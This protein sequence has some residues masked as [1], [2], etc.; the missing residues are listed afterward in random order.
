MTSPAR[1]GPRAWVVWILGVAAYVAAVLQRTS[2]GVAGLEATDRFGVPASGLAAFT[3]LQLLVYAALQVPAG[4][5]LDRFGSRR[6]ITAGA[7]VMAA[8]Q[9]VLAAATAV[10]LAVLGRV[11]VGAGDAV[12]FVSVL[13]LVA[14]WFPPARV[15]L[16]AQVTGLVGQ[17]GQILSAVPLVALL[18][19]SGWAPAFGGAAAVGVVVA[20]A[21]WVG[22]LDAPGVRVQAGPPL[23]FRQ[24]R[25][26]LASAWRHPGTRLGLWT[27][28]TTQFPGTVFALVW[29]YPFLV[30][31]EGLSP[32]V[33]SALLTVFVLAGMVAGPVLG[34]MA[35]RHPLRRSWL[36]LATIGANVAG[37][38]A[39]IAHPGPAP[40][41]LLVVLVLALATGGPGSLVGLDFA[42]T[43][44]PVQRL[45]TA[46]GLVNIGG[47][48]ASLLVVLAVGVVL[49]LTGGEY[50]LDGF[51]LAFSTQ[52][53]V[54]AVGL[55]GIL[56]TRRLVRRRMADEGLV[57]PPLRQALARERLAR[58]RAREA[59]REARRR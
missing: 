41:W 34:V 35:G 25:D 5:A 39:V 14:V 51:R 55:V 59:A 15:P 54:W 36:V 40:V 30:S 19:G 33:A 32:R 58:R 8:G 16:V 44:N 28:F 9:V 37:W 20:L 53:L 50:D 6:L 57:V 12:T 26:D 22:V 21:V 23:S 10:P 45:G 24:A 7:L 46:T 38:T 48:V 17:A 2:F 43:S 18:T 1:L 47:F 52:Y 4:L 42:R 3:V 13:R 11:L 49:D 29:G 27:H 31:A 56:A